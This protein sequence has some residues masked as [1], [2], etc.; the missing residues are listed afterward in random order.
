ML[1]I[2]FLS[3]SYMVFG[4]G[5]PATA[6]CVKNL[7]KVATNSYSLYSKFFFLFFKE[8]EDLLEATCLLISEM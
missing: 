1:S 4:A 7:L 3:S 5:L 8:G 2:Y 6:I